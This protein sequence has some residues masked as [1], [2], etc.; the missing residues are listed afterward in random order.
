MTVV[1]EHIKAKGKPN[2]MPL[3]THLEQVV[4]VAEKVAKE[5]SMDT[6]IA[7]QGAI[8]H[9]IGKA[10][11]IFQKRL[12]GKDNSGKA[13]RHEIGSV[14]F[15]SLFPEDI[16]SELIEMVIAHHKSIYNDAR[17]RGIL[18]LNKLYGKEIIEYH[19]T[20]W[21]DWSKTANLILNSFGIRT[22]EISKEEAIENYTKALNYC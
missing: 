15:L 1:C 16:H 7:R 12:Y 18:D 5:L 2:F 4:L 9:D 6:Y 20:D 14:F 10:S 22:K 8:L 11:P 17:E 3:V 19:L 13:Y 21:D